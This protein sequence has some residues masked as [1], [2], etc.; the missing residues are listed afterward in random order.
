MLGFDSFEK[1]YSLHVHAELRLGAANAEIIVRDVEIVA[2]SFC[3]W[4]YRGFPF[5]PQLL[6]RRKGDDDAFHL[7]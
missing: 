7:W 3:L 6:S 1:Q 4:L 5:F 2:L